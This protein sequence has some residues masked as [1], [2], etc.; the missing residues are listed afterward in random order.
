[1]RHHAGGRTRK[2]SGNFSAV[3]PRMESKEMTPGPEKQ[4]EKK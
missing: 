1:M 4:E 3:R 2:S